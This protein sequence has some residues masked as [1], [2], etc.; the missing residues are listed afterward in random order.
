MGLH[1]NKTKGSKLNDMS[2]VL[3]KRLSESDFFWD[4][5]LIFSFSFGL[6]LSTLG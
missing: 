3:N 2:R 5:V 1:D 4:R 6:S